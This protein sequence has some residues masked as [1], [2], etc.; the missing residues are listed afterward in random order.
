MGK[1]PKENKNS[2]NDNQLSSQISETSEMYTT[3]KVTGPKDA[4]RKGIL[5]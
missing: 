2:K 4:L 1:R 5:E 3:M